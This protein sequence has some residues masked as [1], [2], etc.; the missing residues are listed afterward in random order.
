MIRQFLNLKN[1]LKRES[2]KEVEMLELLLRLLI[3]ASK[4]KN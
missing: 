3:E 1:N 2:N 4:K